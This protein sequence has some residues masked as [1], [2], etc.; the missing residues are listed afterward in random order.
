M[1]I[2]IVGA[3]CLLVGFVAGL[4]VFRLFLDLGFRLDRGLFNRLFGWGFR[5]RCFAASFEI[6]FLGRREAPAWALV[7]LA[8]LQALVVL[9]RTIN[10]L[11]NLDD[12]AKFLVNRLGTG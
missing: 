2:V 5:Q 6:G 8:L 9:D 7:I 10:P 4:L 3:V 11:A 1:S 12:D